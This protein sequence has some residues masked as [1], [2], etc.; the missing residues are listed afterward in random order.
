MA[1][2]KQRFPQDMDY[3]ISLDTTRAV[4]EGMKEIVETLL[5]AIV[6]VIVVVYL[7]LQELARDADSAAGRAGLA[8]RH[9]CRSFRCSAFP[10]THF[11]FSAWCWPSAWWWTMRSSW[12]RP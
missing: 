3:V 11:R 9:V 5:I 6:L 7:F 10:S 4:T 2:L 8:G 12:S 1:E